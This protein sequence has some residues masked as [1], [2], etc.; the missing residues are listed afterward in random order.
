MI[1]ESRLLARVQT[2]ALAQTKAPSHL[3]NPLEPDLQAVIDK[4]A[5]ARA[6]KGLLEVIKA[7][8]ARCSARGVPCH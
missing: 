8:G 2:S 7:G 4:I 5:V 6:V 3:R 1:E